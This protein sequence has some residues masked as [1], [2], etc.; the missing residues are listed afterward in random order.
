MNEKYA[1]DNPNK[2]HHKRQKLHNH[3]V[4]NKNLLSVELIEK[5]KKNINDI[6][7]DMSS[8]ILSL[9]QNPFQ[10]CVIK[11]FL[12]NI[13]IVENLANE[14]LLME[15]NRTQMD[16]Y[17]F[18]Q[19]TDLINV[20]VPYLKSF[21]KFLKSDILS[22]LQNLYDTELTHVS[23]SCSMYTTGDY[24]L[25]HDDLLSD[26]IIAF[27]YYLSPWP[28]YTEW[29][30]EMGGALELFNVDSIGLPTFPVIKSINPNNNQFVFFKVSD[31]SF[32]QVGEILTFEYPRLT[33]NGWFHGPKKQNDSM[34]TSKYK[35]QLKLFDDIWLR[36]KNLYTDLTLW[37]NNSY[38]KSDFKTCLQ[39]HMEMKSEVSLGNFMKKR[40][41]NE[42]ETELKTIDD[43]NW[44]LKGP[45]NYRNYE[46]LNL[47]RLKYPAIID[48]LKLFNSEQMFKLLYEY[49]DLDLAGRRKKSPTYSIEIQRW[50][51]GCYIVLGDPSL[52]KENT[53]D[54]VVHFNVKNV[55]GNIG[56]ITYVYLN[57]EISDIDESVEYDK[58]NKEKV[59][60]DSNLCKTE[61]G[62][63]DDDSDSS[64]SGEDQDEYED[65]A[66]LS[67]LTKYNHL[68]MV[69]RISGT[70][71]ICNYIS[72]NAVNENFYILSV[73]YKE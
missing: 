56:R 30:D 43:S 19:T 69:Y 29:T 5:L 13:D 58:N 55:V 31:I 51:P 53:L 65:A 49:T 22:W 46:I 23:A 57:S 38:L 47:D 21:Y 4:I 62:V 42:I 45:A 39:K 1:K 8:P 14:M 61:T 20:D 71:R 35:Y 37:I 52:Y 11:N 73:R 27:V 9:Y 70:A 72:K 44:I 48:L 41:Y 18:F 16:L 67:I 25:P 33:I 28:N 64:D 32:H 54:I 59:P 68:N 26:R 12:Q 2:S 15:W 50:K 24:L 7:G 10:I 3:C 40:F 36:E 6:K 66:L 63:E 17:R 34:E 60:N